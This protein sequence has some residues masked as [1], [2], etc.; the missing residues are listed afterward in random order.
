MLRSSFLVLVVIALAIAAD[1]SPASAEFAVCNAS[2][3]GTATVAYAATWLDSDGN[4]HG[5]SQGWFQIDQGK[6]TIII[7]T[8]DVSGY[9]IYL[10]GSATGDFWG[11]QDANYCVDPSDK[12]L[13]QGKAMLTPCAAGKSYGMRLLTSGGSTPFTYYL[14]D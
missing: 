4:Q 3:H 1:S 8:L 10:Y 11:G 14:R 5:Q 6:C 13:Y 7:T 2:T 12:F 9:T